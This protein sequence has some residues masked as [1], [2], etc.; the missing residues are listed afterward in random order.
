MARKKRRKK[1]P[2]G[3]GSIVE[4]KG[5]YKPFWARKSTIKLPDGSSY[6]ESLGYFE[7]YEEAYQALINPLQMK[8][9]K[10]TLEH[11]FNNLMETN[12]FKSMKHDTK[13]RYKSDFERLGVLRYK[14]IQEVN[15][16]M[17][18][19]QI[20]EIE[21][22]G[23][24]IKL[25]GKEVRK[26][27][28]RDKMNKIIT[29]ISKIYELAINN[30]LVSYNLATNLTTG[31]KNADKVFKHFTLKDINK[32]FRLSKTHFEIKYILLNI[33][34]GLRPIEMVSLRKIHVDIFNQTIQGM[35]AK[36]DTGRKRTIVLAD[37]IMPIV[38]ELYLRTDD[39]MLGE[40]MS[41][42]VYRTRI[43]YNS[44]NAVNMLDGRTPYACRD[45]FAY[46]MNHFNVDKETIKQ[47]MGHT[48]YA[49]SSDNYIP[50]D[51]EKARN[52]FKK[53]AF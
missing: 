10:I 2:H 40:K 45:T 28:S 47:M 8:S 49:T 32:L 11:L 27:Y 51:A 42:D 24:K 6:R 48:E 31:A 22:L 35:G 38:K 39:Y 13:V 29:V 5:R 25:N 30:N 44:L 7:T 36:T 20:D 19:A 12:K 41:T 33:F 46:L 3:F 1:L 17:L 16:S 53:I 52:E 15:H 34:T 37:R 18:Q 14:S 43:F 21:R 9:S 23:Y 50:L 4:M 26:D